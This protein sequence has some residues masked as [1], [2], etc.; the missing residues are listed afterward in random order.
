MTSVTSRFI[1]TKFIL[2]YGGVAMDAGKAKELALQSDG[3]FAEH[4]IEIAKEQNAIYPDINRY[5][6][7]VK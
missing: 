2:G 1:L 7:K 5:I 3:Y 4:F 6:S